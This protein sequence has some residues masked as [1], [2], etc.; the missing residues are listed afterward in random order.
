MSEAGSVAVNGE[1]SPLS[2]PPPVVVHT[3]MR[4]HVVPVDDD[5]ASI[6]SLSSYTDS[7]SDS[8]DHTSESESED[9]DSEKVR[10]SA[11]NQRRRPRIII[12]DAFYDEHPSPEGPA[13]ATTD[14]WNL[15][16]RQV[17]VAD[18]SGGRRGSVVGVPPTAAGG[19]G[20]RPPLWPDYEASS[21][22][23]TNATAAFIKPFIYDFENYRFGYVLVLELRFFDSL[24]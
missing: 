6:L 7:D 20:G 18:V 17:P 8:D 14:I 22:D 13:T 21:A 3:P 19:N 23:E 24:N 5:A 15:T 10:Q 1:E 12:S 16:V 2:P 4:E 11:Q 9:S